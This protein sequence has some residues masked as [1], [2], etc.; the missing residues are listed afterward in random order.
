M[1]SNEA[2]AKGR[3]RPQG[4]AKHVPPSK[5][6]NYRIFNDKPSRGTRQGPTQHPLINFATIIR[7]T[8]RQNTWY[9]TQRYNLCCSGIHYGDF[10][11]DL[12]PR[13][14][15]SD[16]KNPDNTRVIAQ[17]TDGRGRKRPFKGGTSGDFPLQLR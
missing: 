1:P 7:F 4:V 9:P 10:N 3:A 13:C 16:L 15:A 17:P 2:K 14:S 11:R 8:I 6:L 12:K 5:K